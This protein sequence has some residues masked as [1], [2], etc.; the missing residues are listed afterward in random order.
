MREHD[1]QALLEQA[2]PISGCPRL[3]K[4]RPQ[5]YKACNVTVRGPGWV[6]HQTHNIAGLSPLAVERYY[7]A[8]M[9]AHAPAVTTVT[10]TARY[11]ALHGLVAHIAAERG[12]DADAG[13]A[14]L[15][16][17][18][19]TL[20]LVTLQHALTTDHIDLGTV[21]GGDVLEPLRAKGEVSLNET[22]AAGGGGYAKPRWGF[23]GPYRGSEIRLRIVHP[24][25]FR[26]GPAFN[27][28]R[29]GNE[30]GGILEL[31]E[32]DTLTTDDLASAA[33]ACLCRTAKSTDGAWLA[34]LF[35]GEHG[36]QASRR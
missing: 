7:N 29:V 36:C 35:A 9:A 30:L 12:L 8:A 10:T 13:S 11:Y 6:D 19:T 3:Q 20:A 17:S 18:E 33:Q 2:K 27:M 32:R 1:E 24:T 26:P 16:R 21:H 34:E 23:W 28:H 22:S 31:A 15:R 5:G 25:R 14:L 4:I